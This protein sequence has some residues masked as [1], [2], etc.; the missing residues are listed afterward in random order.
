MWTVRPENDTIKVHSVV[1]FFKE[2]TKYSWLIRR[3]FITTTPGLDKLGLLASSG[4]V[5]C[6]YCSFCGMRSCTNH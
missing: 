2:T 6:H 3:W 1:A 4:A 5:R